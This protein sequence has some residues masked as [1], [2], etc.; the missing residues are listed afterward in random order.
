MKNKKIFK[1]VI[2]LVLALI[3]VLPL[4]ACGSKDENVMEL[5]GISM[6]MGMYRL[7]LS[8]QKGNMAYLINYHYGDYNSAEFW[9]TVIDTNSTTNDAYYTYAIYQKA[10]NLLSAVALF[11]EMKLTLP[12]STIKA[13]DDE[14][15][16]FVTEFGGGNKKAFEAVLEGYGF[17][18]EDLR[19]YKIWGAKA[20]AVANE[21][22]GKNGSKIG[23]GIKQDY[24]EHNYYA[25]RQ[26][27]LANFYNVYETDEND[28]IIYYDG[29]GSVAYDTENGTPKMGEDGKLVYYTEDGRIAYDQKSGKPSPVLDEDGYQKTEDYTYDEWLERIDLAS[30]LIELGAESDSVFESLAYTYS[31]DGISATTTIYVAGNVSYQ[32]LGSSDSYVFLDDATEKLA[33][34]KV[35]ELNIIQDESGIHIIRKYALEEG[36]YAKNEYAGWFKDSVYQIYDFNQNLKNELFNTVLSKYH[37]KITVDDELL[38]ST[39]L[40]DAVPNYYYH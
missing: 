9:E 8:I 27:F 36:A 30:E 1:R 23:T 17:T 4:S 2:C 31:D 32:T 6:S 11:E 29:N 13:I 28:D 18:Y 26:I 16:A 5:D 3:L 19:D 38:S 7:M 25:F 35:G 37:E 24:L 40:R 33:E 34:M 21:L 39:T 14:M 20:E 12:D 22:Y 15:N 10:K